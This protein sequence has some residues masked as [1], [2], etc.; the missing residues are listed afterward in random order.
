MDKNA[1]TKMVGLIVG[2]IMYVNEVIY[3]LHD[4]IVN[5]N[6]WDKTPVS[7]KAKKVIETLK[8]LREEL[9]KVLETR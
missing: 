6:T 2:E 1:K 4:T 9:Q 8:A 3:T 5:D 7:R